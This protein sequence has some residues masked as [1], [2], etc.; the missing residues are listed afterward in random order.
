MPLGYHNLVSVKWIPLCLSGLL[1]HI[2]LI[3]KKLQ[4]VGALLLLSLLLLGS[5]MYA[6]CSRMMFLFVDLHCFAY[7][8]NCY[9][10]LSNKF[11]K[12]FLSGIFSRLS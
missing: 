8:L 10:E 3:L 4:R 11:R 6:L 9:L 7:N 5:H 2:F 1:Y 12:L